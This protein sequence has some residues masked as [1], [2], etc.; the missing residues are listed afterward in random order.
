MPVSV[1]IPTR[2]RVNAT[3]LAKRRDVIAEALASA[4]GRALASSRDVVLAR[5]GGYAT[6]RL[7]EPKVVWT[8]GELDRVSAAVRADIEA[9]VKE[10]FSR[11]ASSAHLYDFVRA[12]VTAPPVLPDEIRERVDE[13]RWTLDGDGYL[14]PSYQPKKDLTPKLLIVKRARQPGDFSD[15]QLTLIRTTVAQLVKDDGSLFQR[16]LSGTRTRPGRDPADPLNVEILR[17]FAKRNPAKFRKLLLEAS[18]G[19]AAAIARVYEFSEGAIRRI[20]KDKQAIQEAA[21]SL[22]IAADAIHLAGELPEAAWLTGELERRIPGF[23]RIVALL[24]PIATARLHLQ[25][26]LITAEEKTEDVIFKALN[27]IDLWRYPA[28]LAALASGKQG[29][30]TFVPQEELLAYYQVLVAV[31]A[32]VR[33]ID[34]WLLLYRLSAGQEAD[35][36]EE[37]QILLQARSRYLDVLIDALRASPFRKDPIDK[38]LKDADAFYADWQ[39]LAADKRLEH[40]AAGIKELTYQVTLIPIFVMGVGHDNAYTKFNTKLNQ[41]LQQVGALGSE[42]ANAGKHGRGE[43]Y[44]VLAGK[45]RQQLGELEVKRSL[46]TFWHGALQ[47]PDWA[48]DHDI[49]DVDDHVS[50]WR[51]TD[52][53]IAGVKRELEHPDYANLPDKMKGWQ[54]R[55]DELVKEINDK[56]EEEVRRNKRKFWVR[57][58]ITV[59]AMVVTWGVAGIAEGALGLTATETTL[60]GAGTFTAV[61]TLGQVVALHEEVS[62]RDVLVSFSE[63]AAFGFLFRWFNVRFVA[64]GRYLAPGRD[65]AQLSIVLGADAAVGTG[66]NLG[67][68]LVQTGHMPEDMETFMFSSVVLSAT[69]ALLGGSRLRQQL[70]A[71]NIQDELLARFDRVRQEG[72]AIFDE[73]RR[74]GPSGPDDAQHASLKKRLLTILPEL[75]EVLGRMAGKNFSDEA[76]ASLGL[77]RSRVGALAKIVAQYAEIVRNSQP[78]SA[79]AGAARTRPAPSEVVH[80]L[81]AVGPEAFEYNPYVPAQ[82]ADQM[83]VRFRRAG[84][85]VTDTGG[86]VLRL[87]GAGMDRPLLL[88]P[89]RPSVPPPSIDAIVGGY[90]VKAQRRALHV[91]Q[92]QPDTAKFV[93][94]LTTVAQRSQRTAQRLLRGIGRFLGPQHTAEMEGFSRFLERGGNASTLAKLLSPI[95]TG[96]WF[97]DVQKAL[98]TLASFSPQANEG[99]EIFFELRSG[100]TASKALRVFHN[101]EPQQVVGI[102]ESLQRLA[103]RSLDLGRLI[104]DLTGNVPQKYKAVVGVL[105]AANKELDRFPDAHLAFEDPGLSAGGELR[106]SDF[107]VFRPS[108]ALTRR[109]E[110]KEI[111]RL[112]SLGDDAVRQLATNIVIEVTERRMLTG[113][114][115]AFESIDWRIRSQEIAAAAAR[116]LKISD[117]NDPAVMRQVIEDVKGRL[118]PALEHAV[119]KRALKRG[120]ITEAELTEYRN[121]FEATLPF[122]SF[123]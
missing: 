49:G 61:T 67:L 53:I 43:P 3:G 56:A 45:L 101:F 91:I 90:D 77:S 119:I 38:L 37:V 103:P 72:A 66:I 24:D 106:V 30:S 94:Q 50:W 18:T 114:S 19:S 109:V 23:R 105:L 116:R 118:R 9:L 60:I 27:R 20:D 120:D 17:A 89:G 83:M 21:Q 51:R 96:E 98:R 100:T 108:A 87:T 22:D 13:H 42:V 35:N 70:R 10:T 52:P 95:E 46:M 79:G 44:L 92:G 6:I 11:A 16:I 1:I 31:L 40:V 123:N 29:I 69:G 75:E 121:A 107:R 36:L 65:L 54:Q 2:I 112:R 55:L 111:Y 78:P 25:G 5:R 74:I 93:A 59:V 28:L 33:E 47:L 110:V 117:V 15:E 122:V 99:L 85:E 32:K 73:I 62:A 63:N 7:W 88:L 84:Y 58:G 41:L 57:L 26:Y 48:I 68:T 80:E 102:F 4:A 64:F 86:G 113:S 76:L 104:P 115:R 8:G 82:S 97:M 34:N 81:V 39:G 12:A 71:L 14:I